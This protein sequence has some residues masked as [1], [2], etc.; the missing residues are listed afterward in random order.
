MG[1]AQGKE[2]H[3]GLQAIQAEGMPM[4]DQVCGSAGASPRGILQALFTCARLV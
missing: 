4:T 2:A 3:P 1:G